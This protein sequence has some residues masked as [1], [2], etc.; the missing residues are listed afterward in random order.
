MRYATFGAR[1]LA[2]LPYGVLLARFSATEWLGV[3][4][5]LWGLFTACAAAAVTF[6]AY[7]ALQILIII[8]GSAV[9]PSVITIIGHW[10][11]DAQYAPRIAFCYCGMFVGQNAGD[12]LIWPLLRVH[13]TGIQGW[14][15]FQLIIGLMAMILGIISITR[16][17][18]AAKAR[19]LSQPEKQALNDRLP[20]SQQKN[21]SAVRWPTRR[22]IRLLRDVP[23][24]EYMTTMTVF[25][26][27]M[28]PSVSGGFEDYQ[29]VITGQL[30]TTKVL[31]CL[32]VGHTVGKTG[33][34]WMLVIVLAL[35]ALVGEMVNQCVFRSDNSLAS[36]NLGLE[37]FVSILL[38][39][40]ASIPLIVFDWAAVHFEDRVSRA[41]ILSLLSSILS[42]PSVW[43]T[44]RYNNLTIIVL[45]IGIIGFTSRVYFQTK[46]KNKRA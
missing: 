36:G 24:W 12:L 28:R 3:N 30:D 32:A 6:R 7:L 26:F 1:M 27:S 31:L 34:R 10:Y 8:A 9:I 29:N 13:W 20:N 17:E 43:T 22:D 46:A 4:L 25:A 37:V 2:T 16:A 35:V 11:Q 39:S 45:V 15:V 19:F 42:L 33:M 44:L 40:T 5:I 23:F 21:G 38:Q 14:Q 41:V 18:N